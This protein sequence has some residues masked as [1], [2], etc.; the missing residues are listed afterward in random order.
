M[1]T[2]ET[3]NV[4]LARMGWT[5]DREDEVFFDRDGEPIDPQNVMA[6]M[7]PDTTWCELGAYGD[8]YRLAC[9]AE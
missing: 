6:A 8:H 2:N 4:V 5:F 3:I 9:G 1:A 7:P